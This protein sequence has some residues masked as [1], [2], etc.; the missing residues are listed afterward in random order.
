[1]KTYKV[2]FNSTN[3]FF[4]VKSETVEDEGKGF[5]DDELDDM[6]LK[7]KRTESLCSRKSLSKSMSRDAS[8][9]SNCESLCSVNEEDYLSD[10]QSESGESLADILSKHGYDYKSLF[11]S[12]S[13]RLENGDLIKYKPPLI[14]SQFDYVPPTINFISSDQKCNKKIFFLAFSSFSKLNEKNLDFKV[15]EMPEK[16]HKLL[17]WKMC[18]ITPNIVK[19]TIARSNFK[20]A[21]RK[22]ILILFYLL[23]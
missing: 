15:T 3:F 1:L 19:S 16:L 21:N 9:D 10:D 22:N 2:R 4:V 14:I 6:T 12:L 5:S 13:K 23:F 20:L 18:S 8:V 7:E 17:R 11:T